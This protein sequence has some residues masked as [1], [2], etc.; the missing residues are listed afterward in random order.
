MELLEILIDLSNENI[1]LKNS[2]QELSYQLDNR[3]IMIGEVGSIAEASLKLNGVFEAAE[4]AA[5]QYIE[6]IK[7][8][9][10]SQEEIS[11]QVEAKAQQIAEEMLNQAEEQCS[12]RIE[13]TDNYCKNK[14]EE[15][16]SYCESKIE[17]TDLI[18]K[19]K[20]DKTKDECDEMLRQANDS[21]LKSKQEAEL[22]W[23]NVSEKIFE[24]CREHEFL[25]NLLN[26]QT[27]NNSQ[28]N[29]GTQN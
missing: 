17:E 9:S 11:K 22:Y 10:E 3:N 21:C 14:I 2:V 12:S 23:N 4:A 25:R 29:S 19:E 6:N 24:L 5:S 15:T 26:S 16:E 13:E 20:L 7:R 1:E 27:K 8:I 18:C 28:E